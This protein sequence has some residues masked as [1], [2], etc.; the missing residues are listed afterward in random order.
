MRRVPGRARTS[1]AGTIAL[2]HQGV[3]SALIAAGGIRFSSE[4]P[5]I[6]ASRKIGPIYVDVRRLTTAP[7][8]WK[9]AVA[10]L[11][12]VVKG[13]GEVDA[14]SGGEL[15]DL[16]FSVPVAIELGLPHVA[17]RKEAKSYGTGGRLVGEVKRGARL[18]HVADLV[19]S[20]T[21]SLEW[22]RVLREAGGLVGD[23]VVVFDRDQGG[24]EALK[25]EGVEVHSL[26]KL[27]GEF[28]DYAS[29][30]GAL[31]RADVGAVSGYL[32]DPDGWARSFLE[33]NPWFLAE[34]IQAVGGKLTRS[35]GLEVLTKGYPELRPKIGGLVRN[36]LK[37][38]GLDEGLV[39]QS[40]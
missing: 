1:H 34:R 14:I 31:R 4:E 19:T 24:R 40:P 32:A 11:V 10:E 27:D 39:L 28:L 5:F 26:L 6:L 22:V 16:F 21:S 35:D 25:S 15:A 13:L 12:K 38:L 20:G 30:S 2:K 8:G 29:R 7:E 23:Y 37:E 17:I 36:R 9:T 33:R 3:A 18:A